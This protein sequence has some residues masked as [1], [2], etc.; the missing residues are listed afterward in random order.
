MACP[1]LRGHVRK[2]LAH[3]D[4]PTKTWACPRDRPPSRHRSPNMS[5][6]GSVPEPQPSTPLRPFRFTTPT[7]SRRY[8][9]LFA[10]RG[11]EQGPGPVVS[12]KTAPSPN[13]EDGTSGT[14]DDLSKGAW[15]RLGLLADVSRW[16]DIRPMGRRACVRSRHQLRTDRTGCSRGP[17]RTPPA[18]HRHRDAPPSLRERRPMHDDSARRLL[19]KIDFTRREFV[20]TTLAA[21][22]ALAVQPVSAQTITT[23]TNGLEAGE[24]KIP[25]PDGKIPAL[26]GDAGRGRAVPGHPRRAGDLRRPRAHQGHL[27]PPGQARLPGRRARAVRPAGRR[28]EDRGLPRDHLQGRLQGARRAGDVRPRRDRR[29]GQDVGQG[30]HGQARHHRLLLGR[31]DRLA[32][33]GAQ[34]RPQGGRRLVRPARQP[35]RPAAPEEPDRPGRRRSRPRCSASTAGPTRASRS[36]RSSR[37]ARP[38]RTPNKPAEIVLYPDTPHAF[39]ADYRPSYRKEQAEDGWKR[40]LAWFKKYGVA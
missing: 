26:P 16:N 38:S 12:R 2:P 21:G 5:P 23:D 24:V 33:R 35:A 8:R 13:P 22:F 37:C 34:P 3:L 14:P 30:G 11:S 15:S 39:F 17:D 19:P 18:G 25:V 40:M 1:R 36:S 27:P 31:A 4:M 29:L 10:S 28:L 32:L 20:V 7:S 6:E 9:V